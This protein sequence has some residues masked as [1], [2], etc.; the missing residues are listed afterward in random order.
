MNTPFEKIT[1]ERL[2]ISERFPG[3]Y[4]RV[5]VEG[6]EY[7]IG[8]YSEAECEALAM[9]VMDNQLDDFFDQWEQAQYITIIKQ[10]QAAS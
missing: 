2:F 4:V 7:T 1:V 6:R 9:K 3:W 8:P 10:E 5:V